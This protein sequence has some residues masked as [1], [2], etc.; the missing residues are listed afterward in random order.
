[1]L[2]FEVFMA[3]KIWIMSFPSLKG[4]VKRLSY[5]IGVVSNEGQQKYD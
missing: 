3:L 4:H 2:G 5:I 1:M